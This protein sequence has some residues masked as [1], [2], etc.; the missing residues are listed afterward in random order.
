L[1]LRNG[2]TV[3]LRQ[4]EVDPTDDGRYELLNVFGT[5]TGE[6]VSAM[7]GE[8]LPAAPRGYSWRRVA[9]DEPWKWL[10]DVCLKRRS[11]SS[12]RRL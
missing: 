4:F 2:K 10:A 7:E 12:V 11:A 1:R 5:A 9:V 8:R 6:A 3:V